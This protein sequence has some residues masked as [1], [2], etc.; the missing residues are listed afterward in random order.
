MVMQVEVISQVQDMDLVVEVDQVVQVVLDKTEVLQHLEMVV[1][2]L[3][4]HQHSVTQHLNL[5]PLVEV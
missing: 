5:A 2:E 4:H 1:L 3:K